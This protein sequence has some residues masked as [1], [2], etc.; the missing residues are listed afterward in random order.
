MS[1]AQGA[2]A[3]PLR[4]RRH[5]HG[6]ERT[7]RSARRHQR[8]RRR[9]RQQTVRG[10]RAARAYSIPRAPEALHR[11]AR[12]GGSGHLSDSAPRSRRAIRIRRDTVSGW[13]SSR[14]RSAGSS[15]STNTDLAALERG[16]Y[17]HDIGKIAV[18][19]SVL[20]KDGKL[21]AQEY[22]VMREHPVVGDA[23]CAG[24]RSLQAV[25]PIVRSHHER[26][27]GSGYP[28]GLKN[29]E[30]PL[31]A[32]IVSIVDVFDALTMERP[33]TRR[34]RGKKRSTCCQRKRQRAGATARWWTRSSPSCR[35]T[36][37]DATK[38][39][40]ACASAGVLARPTSGAALEV[41]PLLGMPCA[42]AADVAAQAAQR[43]IAG[44]TEQTRRR[45]GRIDRVV[46][47]VHT[48][49]HR[50]PLRGVRGLVGVFRAS[51]LHRAPVDRPAARSRSADASSRSRATS[52][53][54]R[55]GR[56]GL[57]RTVLAPAFFARRRSASNP[58]PVTTTI[59]V[60]R[61]EDRGGAACR[62]RNRQSPAAASR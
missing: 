36:R 49:Q 8:R 52:L 30:V 24:L 5:R 7:G 48:A 6:A 1:H 44:R 18:P 34:G 19:D 57:T 12:I 53:S 2:E 28:D 37:P 40:A 38:F 58:S 42:H 55:S 17:L 9:L 4:A 62:D 32:Q 14:P 41:V 47:R 61:V 50:P 25:R 15:A 27:D 54:N 11:R 20:L 43:L 22:R 51:D 59:G 45:R 46:P 26:L 35:S 39:C 13:R 10:R 29:A 21:D 16:G 3:D 23:L 33:Y 56:H 60:A 31:L